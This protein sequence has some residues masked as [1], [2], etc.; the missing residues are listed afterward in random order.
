MLLPA[1][2][3]AKEQARRANCKS[4][5]RQFIL[6]IHLY[7]GDNGQWVPSGAANPGFRDEH[8]PLLSAA[9]SNSIMQYLRNPQMFDCPAFASYFQNDAS[10]QSEA[11][12]RG[13][14]IGYNYHGGHTNTPWDMTVLTFDYPSNV[15]TW[16]SPQRLADPIALVLVSDMNDWSLADGR[17]WAPHGK[18][19]PILHGV[20]ESN[21]GQVFGN[22]TSAQ[23]GAMGGNVGLLDGSVF[24]RNINKMHIYLGSFDSADEGC[25][26]MW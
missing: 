14:V 20:D 6:A 21:R 15:A 26:A 1:L 18:N 24:W 5:E 4:C 8:L 12:G 11:M 19:G 3:G 10:L 16:V 17:T 23:I 2:A 13:C 9:T 25:I 22:P 7:A